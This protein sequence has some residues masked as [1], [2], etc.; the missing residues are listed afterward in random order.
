MVHFYS[1]PAFQSLPFIAKASLASFIWRTANHIPPALCSLCPLL[2]LCSLRA[3]FLHSSWCPAL[4]C[5]L[6]DQHSPWA[7]CL[8]CPVSLLLGSRLSC[9]PEGHLQLFS[10]FQMLLLFSGDFCCS[11]RV[12]RGFS[13]CL[14]AISHIF[15]L[16]SAHCHD[17]HSSYGWIFPLLCSMWKEA[18]WT[19]TVR[20]P[21]F[22]GCLLPSHTHRALTFPLLLLAQTRTP[23]VSVEWHCSGLSFGQG[24]LC[25]WNSCLLCLSP[26]TLLQDTHPSFHVEKHAAG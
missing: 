22:C 24:T 13:S 26:V 5:V 17:I 2:K 3:R 8:S 14:C 1:F 20:R 15:L 19:Y 12:S 11:V 9:D 18:R 16:S 21:L 4:L 7:C 6:L 10:S 25:F 23:C